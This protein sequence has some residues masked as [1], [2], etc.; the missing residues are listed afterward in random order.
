MQIGCHTLE[1]D[2]WLS[3]LISS[4]QNLQERVDVTNNS[5]FSREVPKTL[6]NQHH[7]AA[8]KVFYQ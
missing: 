8:Y 4:L 1:P 2:V 3:I 6:V 7:K 5:K